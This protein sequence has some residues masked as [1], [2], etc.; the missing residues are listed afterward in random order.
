MVVLP[1]ATWL[2][3]RNI[4]GRSA[5]QTAVKVVDGVDGDGAADP[6]IELVQV[7]AGGDARSGIVGD[8]DV[9]GGQQ[10]QGVSL[11]F[12]APG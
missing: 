10:E 8:L 1:K 2:V 11:A 12:G 5:G 7:G 6:R 4:C 9:A 3:C